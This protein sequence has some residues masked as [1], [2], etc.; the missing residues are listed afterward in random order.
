MP[1]SMSGAEAVPA[2][3]DGRVRLAATPGLKPTT[4]TVVLAAATPAAAGSRVLDAGC[5]SAAAALCLAAR[6]PGCTILGVEREAEPARAARANV[7]L[8]GLEDRIAI[9]RGD[10]AG[11]PRG[12][13][14]ETFDLVMT[15]PPHLEAGRGRPPRDRLRHAAKVETMPLERWI[16]CCLRMLRPGGEIVVLHRPDREQALLSALA[17]GAGAVA[18]LR[19]DP[20]GSAPGRAK[21][22]LMRAR[23]GAPLSFGACR[24]L[25][26]HRTGGGWSARA[27]AILRSGDALDWVELDAGAPM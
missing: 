8:N 6:V 26:L 2:L 25:V 7:A 5:G 20:G 24:P 4:D 18:C 19:L 21:R 27:E 23:K 16:A 13:R 17:A 22:L 15:N 11:L 9:R 10:L 3:L 14:A 1:V 12:A